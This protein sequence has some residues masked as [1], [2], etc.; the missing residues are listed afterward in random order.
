[1]PIVRGLRKFSLKKF[2]MF[3]LHALK[4]WPAAD[5]AKSLGVSLARSIAAAV[6]KEMARMEREMERGV[7]RET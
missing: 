3:D 4:E 6:K 1:M 2:Q 5:V 7:K